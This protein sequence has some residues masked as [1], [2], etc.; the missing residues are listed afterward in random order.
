L[1]YS[2]N[3]RFDDGAFLDATS[4]RVVIIVICFENFGNFLAR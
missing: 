1:Q 3:H 4:F 2:A